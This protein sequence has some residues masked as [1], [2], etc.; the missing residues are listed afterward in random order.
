MMPGTLNLRTLTPQHFTHD[1]TSQFTIYFYLFILL[2]ELIVTVQLY[3]QSTFNTELHML[4]AAKLFPNRP[5][6]F[7]RPLEQWFITE[8]GMQ[9]PKSQMKQKT[10]ET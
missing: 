1:G 3:I 8:H 4:Y 6:A 10:M 5:Q 2:R 7:I 9:T